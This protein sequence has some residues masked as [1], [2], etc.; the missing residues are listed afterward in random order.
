M[1]IASESNYKSPSAASAPGASLDIPEEL[2]Q[3]W[4]RHDNDEK[5]IPRPEA[6]SPY[7][8][9]RCLDKLLRIES[10]LRAGMPTNKALELL[11]GLAT[12]Q[13]NLRQRPWDLRSVAN[14]LSM[15]AA[16]G[17]PFKARLEPGRFQA[18]WKD[19]A[20]VWPDLQ[21][22]AESN[23]ES[24]VMQLRFEVCSQMLDFLI[25]DNRP[26]NLTKADALLKYVFKSASAPV[27]AH[28]LLIFDRDLDPKAMPDWPTLK[29]AIQVH[30][31]AE[32]VALAG[33]AG[34]NEFPASEL[35]FPWI[36]EA[37]AK[38]DVERLRGEDLLFSTVPSDWAKAKTLLSSAEQQ[39][40]TIGKQASKVR[41]ALAARNQ[42]LAELPY[43]ARWVAGLTDEFEGDSERPRKLLETVERSAEGMHRLALILESADPS[44]LQE[45]NSTAIGVQAGLDEIRGAFSS[46][47]PKLGADVLISKWHHIDNALQVP[48][49]RASQRMQLLANL[50][51]ISASLNQKFENLTTPPAP[52]N[53]RR[54]SPGTRPTPGPHRVGL[55]WNRLRQRSASTR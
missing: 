41:Q 29:L 5:Q 39:Y 23:G 48:F 30:R 25:S 13:E 26:E 4:E 8:S 17:S 22:G 14:S 55:A 32:Q 1:A 6:V 27:E 45:L 47:L 44:R 43:Y 7:Q 24:S 9:R 36:R 35:V 18:L 16:A 49:I 46:L 52:V 2:R 21:A 34:P 38:A 54:P 28:V 53:T 33:G 11:K 31:L 40:Q 12:E 3:A 19:P 51:T 50:R 42:A 37:V 20:N 15:P 10:M